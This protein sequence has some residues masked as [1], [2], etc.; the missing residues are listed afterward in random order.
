MPVFRHQYCYMLVVGIWPCLVFP[1]ER[2]WQH[3]PCWN[4]LCLA[5]CTAFK[6][7]LRCKSVLIST[8]G[9][10]IMSHSTVCDSWR[11][12]PS[13]FCLVRFKCMFIHAS[14][15]HSQSHE[16]SLPPASRLAEL[17]AASARSHQTQQCGPVYWEASL[18][19]CSLLENS[20]LMKQMLLK[21]PEKKT[22]TSGSEWSHV[23]NL[24]RNILIRLIP[25]AIYTS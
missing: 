25:A 17:E 2:V 14:W 23:S 19:N 9:F 1:Q 16:G 18:H 4:H 22:N 15:A 21:H 12:N 24:F 13:V 5:R 6:S 11:M 8:Q 10:G 20:E 7:L 3:S